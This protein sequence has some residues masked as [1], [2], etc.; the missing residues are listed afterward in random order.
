MDLAKIILNGRIKK[1]ISQEELARILGVSKNSIS[2]WE[3]GNY[4]PSGETLVHVASV[5]D[6]VEDLFPGYIKAD[7]PE[8]KANV[9]KGNPDQESISYE[10]EKLWEAIGRIE[11]RNEGEVIHQQ[12]NHATMVVGKIENGKE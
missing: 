11:R 3:R 4:A 7:V 12:D 10:I 6:I 9:S 8:K 1:K 5:L 2:A